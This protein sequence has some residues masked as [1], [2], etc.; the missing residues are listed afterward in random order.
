MILY[1][2]LQDMASVWLIKYLAAIFFS[3]SSLV[4]KFISK[5]VKRPEYG[6]KF[7]HY[8]DFDKVSLISLVYI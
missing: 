8:S 3:S 2:Y 4:E 7:A 6:A 1:C 5:S